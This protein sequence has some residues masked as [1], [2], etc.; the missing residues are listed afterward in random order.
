MGR[1]EKKDKNDI[2]E[3]AKREYIEETGDYGG[4]SKYLDFADFDADGE[5]N[6]DGSPIDNRRGNMALF[7]TG[8]GN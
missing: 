5:S 2:V 8:R 6:V 1:R 4:L 3:T 7:W